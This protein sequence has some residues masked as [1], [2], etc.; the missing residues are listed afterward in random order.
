MVSSADGLATQAGVDVLRKR[1]NA[2][3]A[4]IAT[5][6]VLAVVAPHLCG[7][8]GD[9]FALVMRK[10]EQAPAVLDA[11]GRAGSGA[12]PSMLIAE[13]LTEMPFRRDVRSVTVPGCVDGW[14][15]LHERY[16]SMPLDELLSRALAYAELGFPAS[17]LLAAASRAAATAPPF[18]RVTSRSIVKRQPLADTLRTIGEAHSPAEARRR[19]YGQI[20]GPAL[21]RLDSRWFDEAD[22][23]QPLASWV[24]PL[25]MDV[26]DHRI[27]TVPPSSQGYLSLATA[28]IAAD[29]AIPTDAADPAWAHVLV[30]A[31]KH[32]AHDRPIVL[33]DG[34]DGP[35]LLAAAIRHGAAL[36]REQASSTT[37]PTGDGDTTYLAVVDTD[38]MAV[39]LIQSNAS[40]F[41]S[42]LW[43]HESGINLHNRGI[44]FRLDPTSA[45][46]LR[47]GA[48][49][50]HTLSPALVTTA[51]GELRYVLG[52]M[53]GDA[54]PQIVAQL[55]ARLLHGGAQPAQA[56]GAP[57]WVLTAGTDGFSTWTTGE[58]PTVAIEAS[59]ATSWHDDLAARGHRIDVLDDGDPT[60]GHAHVIA[61]GLDGVLTASADWRCLVGSAAGF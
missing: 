17:P 60:F 35:S 56:V 38:G 52:T 50:P 7:M 53:G 25:A 46:A 58:T 41:G 51:G 4:A 1:G 47:P 9:L 22:M 15:A 12:D 14:L 37:A 61:A 10:G 40:G 36:D 11:S 59:A 20:I 16:G 21:L 23:E 13:G 42:W 31:A 24:E 43:H 27:W 6:A 48:R 26:W 18:G 2:V 8:G 5:N 32:A 33:G 54:Q 57:R 3:D 30:E 39:S 55:L 29:H 34:A 44:G 28:A 19:F 45:G 49:P